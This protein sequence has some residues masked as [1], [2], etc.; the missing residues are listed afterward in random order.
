MKSIAVYFVQLVHGGHEEGGWYYV[1]GERCTDPD[2]LALGRTVADGDA[3]VAR[4]LHDEMQA[5][6]DREWNTGDHAR[7]ISSVLSPGRYEAVTSDGWPPRH[8]P[9]SRPVYE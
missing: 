9:E 1:A 8:F 2:F 5:H 6:L 4:R 3:A 7:D